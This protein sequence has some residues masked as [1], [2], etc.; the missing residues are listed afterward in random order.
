MDIFAHGAWSY[1]LFHKSKKPW[2]A[3][4]FGL[5]PDLVSFAPYFI[6]RLFTGIQIGGRPDLTK[7]PAWVFTNYGFGHSL[8]TIALLLLV[9]Y[10]FNKKIPIYVWAWPI[11]ILVDIPTHSREFLPTPFLW[12]ISNWRFPGISWGTPWFMV[13][14]WS[15]IIG[16][17]LTIWILRKKKN[18]IV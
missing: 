15:L 3:V 14:N 9:I 17:L 11:A 16:F 7:V 5:L 2:L 13:L 1:I 6:Y 4:L 10:M 12:P 18:S 8:F